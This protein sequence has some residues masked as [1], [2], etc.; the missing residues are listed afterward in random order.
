MHSTTCAAALAALA[1][2]SVLP[3]VPAAAQQD[4]AQQKGVH[5]GLTYQPGTKPGVVVLPVAGPWGDSVQAMVARDLDYSDRIEII[6]GTGT[7]ASA[8]VEQAS[9]STTPNYGLWK[10]LGAAAVVAANM[11]ATGVHVVLHDVNAGRVA[12]SADFTLSETPGTESW[13]MAVH[14]VS[15]EIERWITGTRGIAQTRILYVRGGHIYVIDSDGAGSRAITLTGGTALS[16]AWSPD[17]RYLTYSQLHAQGWRIMIGDLVTGT[18]RQVARGGLNETPTFS[19]DGKLLVYAHGGENGTDLMVTNV[20]GSGTP[21]PLTAGRG[22]INIQPSFSPDG[23]RLVFTS[24]RIGHNEVYIM[25]AD[26]SNA[27]PLTTYQFGDQNYRSD[28][29]WSPDGLQVAFQAR[30]DGEFQIMTITL[31]DRSVT[32]RTSEGRNEEPSWAPD[33]RHLVFTSTRSGA[34]QLWVL[35]VESGRERQLTHS[36]ASRLPAWSGRLGG[37]P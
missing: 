15:D 36:G 7:D 29:A 8:V 19:P 6:G 17:G 31:R 14:G 35:D 18:V 12:Q 28:P 26:G 37:T 23:R 1:L 22:R 20:T 21:R 27:A 16:P 5:I 10:T 33:G 11:T 30:M 3:A 25:D 9:A 4:T 32:Q 34:K 24:D 13:R 2:F